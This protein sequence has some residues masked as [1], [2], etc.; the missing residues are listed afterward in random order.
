M[1]SDRGSTA[2]SPVPFGWMVPGEMRLYSLDRLEEATRWLA[3]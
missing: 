3:G 2:G 1:S